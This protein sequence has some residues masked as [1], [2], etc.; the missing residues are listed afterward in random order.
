M[1]QGVTFSLDF[2][3]GGGAAGALMRSRDWSKSPLGPPSEWPQSLRS[4]VGLLLNSS[5]PMFVAWGAELGFLYNDAYSEILGDKHPG[6]MGRRF[7]EVWPEIWPDISPLIETALAGEASYREDLP[8]LVKRKGYE[9]QTSFTFSY[10]PVRD[11]SGAVAGMFCACNETTEKLLTERRLRESE[12]RFREQFENAND[13]IFTAD[14]DMRVTSCNPAVA[15]ALGRA[16]SDLIGRSIAE[17][18]PPEIWERT[19]AML[20]TKLAGEESTRYEVEVFDRDKRRMT[21]EINSRLTRDKSGAPDGLHAIGRDVTQRRRSENELRES[22]ERFR[23]AADGSPALM[24]MTDERAEVTFANKRYKS[25]FGVEA[26]EMLGE[27]WRSIVHPEDVD[28]FHALFLT[29]LASRAP[30]HGVVRVLH[31]ELG[32]RWLD[33]NGGPRWAADGTFLGYVGVNIDVTDAVEAEAALRREEQRYRDLANAVPAFIWFGKPNGELE[34]LNDRWYEYTGQTRAEALPN[35]WADTLHPDDAERTALVWAHARARGVR[36]EVEIR[37]RRRDGVYRWYVAR[38]EPLHDEAGEVRG[39]FGTSLDVHDRREATN[40]LRESEARLR[41]LTDHLPGGMVYQIQSGK[42]GGERRF[43]YVSQSYEKLTGIPAEAVLADPAA[44][45]DMIHP[46]DRQ[47]VGEAEEEALRNRSQF[48]VEVRFRRADGELRWCRIISAPREQPDGSLIWDGIQID[49]T[50]QK[51]AEAELRDREAQLRLALA[52]GRLAEVTFQIADDG[53]DHGEAYARLLGHAPDKKLTL[54]EVRAAYHPDDRDRVVSERRAILEG[55]R[56]FYEVEKRVVWPDGQVRWIYGRGRVNRDES[57]RPVTVTAIYLDDTDRKLAEQELRRFNETLEQRVAERTAELQQAHEQLRQ[58]QKLEAMGQLTG[59]VAHD[60][61]NLLTPIIGGLDL[62]KRRGLGGE[63]EQRLIDGALQ[64]AERA[65]TLVQRLL[66][67]ARRQ[68]LKA[69]AVDVAALVTG[70]ADLIESTSGPQI[71]LALDLHPD[72]PPAKADPNQLEMA[73][74]NLSVN[75]RDAMPDGGTLTIAAAGERVESGHRSKLRPGEYVRLSVADTGLGMDEETLARAIEPFF[76]TKGIGKG[77]GLGLSMVHGLAAQLGGA[78]AIDSRLGLG[79]RVELWLPKSEVA[80]DAEAA[81]PAKAP[82]NSARGRALLV[83]DE[84]L[85]RMST[86]DMLGDL[87]Y[88][89][90]E[91]NSAAAA[92]AQ[93]DDGLEFNLLVTD[94]LMPGMTGADLARHVRERW[95]DLPVLIVSGYAETDG[96][97]PDLPRLSKPFRQDDLVASLSA[98]ADRSARPL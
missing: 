14:L 85:V 38:A 87:G 1:Q 80:A 68:P 25:F 61:N 12:A 48:D 29:A 28:D 5:F 97:A 15:A 2:L 44:A 92:L 69:G 65:K 60:F 98:I 50:A 27:G 73:I 46:D 93:L 4:V 26:E 47:R 81:A 23:V 39:W 34:Y 94:H 70:M 35:G 96:L 67:F 54:A 21:W 36:Y 79:T 84:D 76:S 30:F 31:P 82:S 49:I 77:T 86:A 62:L 63:R 51:Q 17:F 91:A 8:L 83:D 43:V 71:R 3:S 19:R 6:A 13:F 16:P 37:Y 89:V 20:A 41:A 52:A 33:C 7:H 53:V 32:T 78:F 90:V 18:V 58:S 95:P 40:K 56:D 9:E 57:G 10:S 66:A 55:T 22:E 24:W 88:E 72:V 64:S 59:G 42:D 74:L 45:Y 75:A 11:E